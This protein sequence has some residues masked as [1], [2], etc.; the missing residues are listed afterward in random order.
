MLGPVLFALACFDVPQAKDTAYAVMIGG[1]TWSCA[2]AGDLAVARAACGDGG[3]VIWFRIGQ[4][5]YTLTDDADLD[6]MA[7]LLAPLAQLESRV[8]GLEEKIAEYDAEI[9]RLKAEGSRLDEDRARYAG[10]S[11]KNR[12]V[13]AEWSAVEE[14]RRVLV[15]RRAEMAPEQERLRAELSRAFADAQ[16]RLG[17]LIDRALRHG[18]AR[19]IGD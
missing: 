15:D 13:S 1:S 4:A 17:L 7:S 11:E 2:E 6:D 16:Q 8:A 14:R 10:G 18:T 9:S 3:D 12:A 5:S 19:S